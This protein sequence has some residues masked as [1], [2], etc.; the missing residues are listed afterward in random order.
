MTIAIDTVSTPV[1][2]SDPDRAGLR[3]TMRA[4]WT[5]LMSLRSTTLT[6]VITSPCACSG[7]SSAPTA[8]LTI[9]AA[10]TRAST[11]LNAALGGLAFSARWS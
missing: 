10:G 11:G 9:P 3:Q 6:L 2:R 4:E 7:P 5:K 1:R 8:P